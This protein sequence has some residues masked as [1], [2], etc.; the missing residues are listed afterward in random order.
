[1]NQNVKPDLDVMLLRQEEMSKMALEVLTPR[2]HRWEPGHLFP[3]IY[4][5]DSSTL[6]V[7]EPIVPAQPNW[8]VNQ[9]EPGLSSVRAHPLYPP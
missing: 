1:M 8:L 7:S 2:P 6:H 5:L 3:R 4:D 9:A